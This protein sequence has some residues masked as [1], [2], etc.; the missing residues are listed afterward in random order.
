MA[1]QRFKLPL[2]NAAFPFVST[3]AARAVFVPGLDAAARTPRGFV[4][5]EDSVDYNLT[6]ILYGENFMPVGSGVR[7]VGYSQLIAPT[8]N[9]DFDSIFPLRDEEENVVLYSPGGGKNYVYNSILSSWSSTTIPTI[10]GKTFSVDSDVTQSRVTY[11]YVD[12]FTFVCFG[13]LKSNDTIPVDMSLL[14]W[15]SS[16]Q[17]LVA[18]A[19]LISNLPFPTGEIDGISS[20]GRQS[21]TDLRIH[22]Y[23]YA[24]YILEFF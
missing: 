13:R 15:D 4:G 11:A 2:N 20:A 8:S 10:Y 24:G 23:G 19:A 7:S 1:V 14:Y 6:Q 5:A 9:T 12:G 22:D 21:W 18:P 3:E 17:S 16:T